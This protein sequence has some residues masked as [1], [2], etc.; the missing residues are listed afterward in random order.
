MNV[1]ERCA[2]IGILD[3]GWKGLG[4]ESRRCLHEAE[5]VI[6][7]ERT[8]ALVRPHRQRVLDH[9]RIRPG[10]AVVRSA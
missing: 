9:G 2:V 7:A 1:P 10:R 8:L 4:E 3:D 5:L 6:G